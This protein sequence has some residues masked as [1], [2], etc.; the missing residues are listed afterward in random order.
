MIKKKK[1]QSRAK[2]TVG[3]SQHNMPKTVTALRRRDLGWLMGPTADL[4]ARS[5]D[6]DV[7]DLP[8][9]EG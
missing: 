5:P 9:I 7:S 4:I 2:A 8:H 3:M 1:L 6:P